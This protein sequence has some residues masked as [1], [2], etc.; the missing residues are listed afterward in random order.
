MC[1]GEECDEA[2]RPDP[3]QPLPQDQCE[4]GRSQQHPRTRNQ[5]LVHV[6]VYYIN[7]A[8]HVSTCVRIHV[9]RCACMCVCVC[10]CACACS[11]TV[12]VCPL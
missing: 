8:P 10:A 4:T 7:F 3:L 2:V 12:C 9:A 6:H 1:A 5:V 11:R